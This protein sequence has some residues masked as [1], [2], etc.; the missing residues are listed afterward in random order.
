ML[1]VQEVISATDKDLPGKGWFTSYKLVLQSG[2][3]AELFQRKES[4]PPKAGDLI[5]GVVEDGPYGKKIRKNAKLGAGGGFRPRDPKE[6]A[7]IQRQHSQDMAVQIAVAAG[8]FKQDWNPHNEQDAATLK[9]LARLTD[10]FQR[11]IQRGVNLEMYGS[12]RDETR[13]EPVRTGESDVPSDTT[14]FEHPKTDL[15]GTPFAV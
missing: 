7:A 1:T 14:G 8:W 9:D 4:P 12:K 13:K 11:D 10:W 2:E 15:Q 3:T 5:D 6:T